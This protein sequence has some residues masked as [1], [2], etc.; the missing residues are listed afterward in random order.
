MNDKY[1]FTNIYLDEKL[2]DKSPFYTMV[3]ENKDVSFPL[4]FNSC[5]E[6]TKDNAH[7]IKKDGKCIEV[8]SYDK[9]YQY[10][11][12]NKGLLKNNWYDLYLTWNCIQDKI[13]NK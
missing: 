1:I 7:Y 12:T 10:F 13:Q 9:D 4:R 8:L 6:L 5:T 2:K 3:F 11:E